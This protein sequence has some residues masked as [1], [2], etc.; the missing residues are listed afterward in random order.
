MKKLITIFVLMLTVASFGQNATW[1]GTKTINQNNFKLAGITQSN[2]DTKMLSID[3][4]GRWH[5]VDKA[6]ITSSIPTLQQVTISGNTTITPVTFKQISLED[7]SFT[8]RKGTDN[9]SFRSNEAADI[10]RGGLEYKMTDS[11]GNWLTGVY[12]N[13]ISS[14]LNTLNGTSFNAQLDAFSGFTSSYSSTTTTT[15]GRLGINKDILTGAYTN[16]SLVYPLKTGNF[17]PIVSINNILGDAEGNI[18]IPLSNTSSGSYT[19]I[20]NNIINVSSSSLNR[21][22]TWT[23]I[24]NVVTIKADLLIQPLSANV[25]TVVRISI[26]FDFDISEGTQYVG[27]SISSSI[28]YESGFIQTSTSS[29]VE[30]F[31]YPSSSSNRRVVLNFTYKTN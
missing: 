13:Y 18:N 12:P 3:N 7:A 22:A 26:P 27:S 9:S 19:P 29:N 6:T 28:P 2:A 1:T 10:T 24:G 8:I 21:T 30:C 4:L 15:V 17:T 14:S 23:K 31:F 20:V 11:D 16:C 5:W 25:N